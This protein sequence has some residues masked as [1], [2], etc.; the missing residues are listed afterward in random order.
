MSSKGVHQAKTVSSLFS[1]TKVDH[2]VVSPLQRTYETADYIFA[3]HSVGCTIMPEIREIYLYDVENRAVDNS[4]LR[5]QLSRL[6]LHSF[7]SPE[8]IDMLEKGVDAWNPELEH[9]KF[10]KQVPKKRIIDSLSMLYDIPYERVA[11][12]TH[13]GY[14]NRI[15]RVNL[16]NC[17]VC[18]A[19]LWKDDFDVVNCAVVNIYPI[20][21]LADK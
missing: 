11:V 5:Q 9:T 2:I 6:R 13:W 12:I 18:E 16:E 15:L 3:D 20:S 1:S 4:T 21:A 7:I 10:H 14:V 19:T 8:N 17:D